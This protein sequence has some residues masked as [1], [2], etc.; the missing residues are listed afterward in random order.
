MHR[1]MS[2]CVLPHALQVLRGARLEQ[3]MTASGDMYRMQPA[4]TILFVMEQIGAVVS[5]D[6]INNE[7]LYP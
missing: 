2:A 7:M 1:S 4:L 5:Q 3:S 6:K